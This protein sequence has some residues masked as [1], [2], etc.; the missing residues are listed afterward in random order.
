[1]YVI[2]A[3]YETCRRL[4]KPLHVEDPDAPTVLLTA[5]TGAAAYNISRLTLHS[6]FQ[7][8]SEHT[9]QLSVTVY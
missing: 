5:L 7:L 4:L 9:A 1:M 3:A 6:V 2:K 8:N